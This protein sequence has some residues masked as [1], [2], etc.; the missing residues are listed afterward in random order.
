MKNKSSNIIN[1]INQTIYN[2]SKEK[3]TRLPKFNSKTGNSTKESKTKKDQQLED[4]NNQKIAELGNNIK[5]LEEKLKDLNSETNNQGE[6]TESISGIPDSYMK[7]FIDIDIKI[8]DDKTS[9]D[10]QKNTNK[11]I[12]GN[13]KSKYAKEVKDAADETQVVKNLKNLLTSTNSVINNL[14]NDNAILFD[15]NNSNMLI[16]NE[17]VLLKSEILKKNIQIEYHKLKAEF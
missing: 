2:Q 14:K 4:P 9:K 12:H 6:K 3:I 11:S 8:D 17:V 5:I 15:K 7:N 1:S 16:S 13:F 10:N